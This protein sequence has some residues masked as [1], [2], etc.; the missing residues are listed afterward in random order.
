[1]IQRLS[2]HKCK[3]IIEMRFIQSMAI[4]AKKDSYLILYW[5]MCRVFSD[6]LRCCHM[7][8]T[9]IISRCLKIIEKVLFNIASDAS[10][11][12]IPSGQKILKNA[13]VA[14]FPTMWHFFI[15]TEKWLRKT[16]VQE[17]C[18]QKSVFQSRP[19]KRNSKGIFKPSQLHLFSSECARK[20]VEKQF[21]CYHLVV[22]KIL[23]SL[24]HYSRLLCLFWVKNVM[25]A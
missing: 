17:S 12:Y 8:S 14:D 21:A 11:V 7:V 5:R 13:K 22:C 4:K 25:C 16:T 3:T 10:Y 9:G 20:R 2:C 23:T 1:M 18:E 24:T 19:H 15:S 6:F